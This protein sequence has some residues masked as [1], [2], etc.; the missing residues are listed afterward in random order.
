MY[1]SNEITTTCIKQ[2]L[3]EKQKEIEIYYLQITLI[4]FSQFKTNKKIDKD[5]RPN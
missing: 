2:K 5:G 1:A 4:Y 3:Q